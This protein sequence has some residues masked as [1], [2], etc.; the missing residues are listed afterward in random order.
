VVSPEQLEH[1]ATRLLCSLRAEMPVE[2][3]QI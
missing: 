1:E 3:G 2:M